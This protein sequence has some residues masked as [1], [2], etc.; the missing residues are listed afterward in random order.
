MQAAYAEIKYKKMVHGA[1]CQKFR[2]L[3]NFV[4]QEDY[5]K[6]RKKADIMRGKTKD[7]VSEGDVYCPGIVASSV[8]DTKPVHFLSMVAEKLV[9]NINEKDIYDKENNKK[10]RIQFYRTEM[11]FFNNNYMNSVHVFDQLHNSYNF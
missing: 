5:T 11:N 7:D 4:V 10:V 8:Y 6:Y 3:T 2:G 1:F 9:C